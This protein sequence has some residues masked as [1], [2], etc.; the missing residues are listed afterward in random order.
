MCPILQYFHPKEDSV[1]MCY[2][3]LANHCHGRSLNTEQVIEI[4]VHDT[5]MVITREE[6][7]KRMPL[8]MS[9]QLITQ[10]G[11][12]IRSKIRQHGGNTP[13]LADYEFIHRS[14]HI[15]AW[16]YMSHEETKVTYTMVSDMITALRDNLMRIALGEC[17]V[18]LAQMIEGKPH[19]AGGGSVGFLDDFAPDG[20]NGALPN[21]P[22]G[23]NRTFPGSLSAQNGTNVAAPN[24]SNRSNGTTIGPLGENIW[25]YR[26]PNTD[27]VIIIGKMAYGRKLPLLGILQLLNHAHTD[28]RL[29]INKYGGNSPLVD[30]IYRFQEDSL[31]VE[32]HK[33]EGPLTWNTVR[34]MVTGLIDCFWHV[35]Y[36]ES[37]I[38]I[39]RVQGTR[40][41]VQLRR[42][43]IV[44]SG[45]I[46]FTEPR[47]QSNT[48]T[49]QESGVST[50]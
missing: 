28:L 7:A 49:V 30:N 34:D 37:V 48:T 24:F 13:L 40:S 45:T 42:D 33:T 15:R 50:A 27:T 12:D 36:V 35:N 21:S 25:N 41:N 11:K 3:M 44:G 19:E 10:A 38:K 1:L 32:A 26:V 23:M 31:E 14:L 2:A 5:H 39:Y 4:T 16:Q 18:D 8:T 46:S 29:Q 47:N 43:K 17:G 22:N 9:S 6:D 20:L